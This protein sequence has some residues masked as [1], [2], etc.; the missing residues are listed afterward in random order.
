MIRAARVRRSLDEGQQAHAGVGHHG[1]RDVR[2]R[3]L[4]E[5]EVR[6]GEAEVLEDAAR[7]LRDQRA[8]RGEDGGAHA[9]ADVHGHGEPVR[10][11]D[12]GAADAARATSQLGEDLLELALD[13]RL[14]RRG[15]D[16]HALLDLTARHASL[17]PRPRAPRPP[18]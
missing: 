18:R 6:G 14:L 5:D 17:L 13:P 15:E 16:V 11:R 8:H 4:H 2:L 12:D 7:G 1:H 3:A 10:V 9:P